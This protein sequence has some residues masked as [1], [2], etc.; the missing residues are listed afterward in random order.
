MTEIEKMKPGS[1]SMQ[2]LN[3]IKKET[4]LSN[5]KALNLT[6]KIVELILDAKN[7][8]DIMNSGF[9]RAIRGG[10]LFKSRLNGKVFAR[11]KEVLE[12]EASEQAGMLNVTYLATLET[13]IDEI[14]EKEDLFA[15]IDN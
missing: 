3:T 15:N 11:G 10:V 13:C 2:I 9:E 1:V 8:A 7:Y 4:R 12:Q 14:L 6:S 5:E